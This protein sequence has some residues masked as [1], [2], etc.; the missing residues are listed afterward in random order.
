MPESLLLK[1][2]HSVLY[3]MR[4]LCGADVIGKAEDAELGVGVHPAQ[5]REARSRE[6]ADLKR[7]K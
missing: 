6:Q 1:P 7:V 3:Q 5:G 4:R 2:V